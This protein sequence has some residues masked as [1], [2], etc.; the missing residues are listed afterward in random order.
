MPAQGGLEELTMELSKFECPNCG[1][2]EMAQ[3][4]RGWLTCSF[5]CSSFGEATRICPSCGEYNA[6]GVHFCARCGGA[7]IRDCPACGASNWILARHCVSCGRSMDVIEQMVRRWQQS[8]RERLEAWQSSVG[9][10]KA[11]EE[12]ASRRRM[13]ALM[14]AESIRQRALAVAEET[15]RRRDRQTYIV[16]SVVVAIFVLVVAVLL[17]LGFGSGG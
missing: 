13:A 3:D 12:E 6:E 17:L 5:C 8:T 16:M 4:D 15:R 11:E 2:K 1:A 7:L 9:R 10:L 14:E